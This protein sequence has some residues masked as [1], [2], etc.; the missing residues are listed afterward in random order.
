MLRV[1]GR[2]FLGRLRSTPT[3]VSVRSDRLFASNESVPSNESVRAKPLFDG[4]LNLAGTAK[5]SRATPCCAEIRLSIPSNQWKRSALRGHWTLPKT[6]PNRAGDVCL[7]SIVRTTCAG[8][9]SIQLT[10]NHSIPPRCDKHEIRL[11]QQAKITK[12]LPSSPRLIQTHA[13][14]QQ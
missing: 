4:A 3:E 2:W 8:R 10:H 5:R 9:D 7:F 6:D 13:Q 1:W 11:R 14:R 12:C